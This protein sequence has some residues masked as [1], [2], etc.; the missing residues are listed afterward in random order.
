MDTKITVVKADQTVFEGD[1]GGYYAWSNSATP[2]LTHFK[3]GAGKL[4]LHPLGFALPHYAD[5]SKIGLVLQGTITVGMVAPNSSEEQVLLIKKGDAVPVL[6]GWVSWWFNGGDTDAS[7]VFLGE[8]TKALVP[9]QFTYFFVCGVLGLLAGFQPDFVAKT[10]GLDQKE[11][12]NLANSQQGALLV[13]LDDD[14]PTKF[15]K[16]SD[17]HTKGKLYA[18]IDDPTGEIVVKGGGFISFLTEKKLGLIGGV[19]LSAKFVK[20]EGGAVLAPSFVADGSIQICYVGMGSGRVKKNMKNVA[21]EMAANNFTDSDVD[22][23]LVIKQLQQQHQQALQQKLQQQRRHE[24]EMRNMKEGIQKQMED[25]RR[26][27]GR[28][29]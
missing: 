7:I 10:F 2:L 13:K 15:P 26:E 18:T 5:S 29:D 23:I 4:L 1:S 9:G 6:A 16:T 19:G 27:F 8:T 3:L 20:L 22:E 21:A 12:E 28:F 17:H 14:A 24:E 11:S 25:T